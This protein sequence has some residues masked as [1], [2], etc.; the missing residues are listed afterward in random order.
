LFMKQNALTSAT[1]AAY[2]AVFQAQLFQLG[3]RSRLRYITLT[4]TSYESHTTV[5]YYDPF[6]Q[7]WSVADPTFG[8]LF[9]D[10]TTQTGQAVEE[11]QALVLANNFAGIHVTTVTT[12]S[13]SMLRNYY[14]DPLTLYTNVLPSDI[15]RI[16]SGLGSQPHSP[17]Q[18]LQE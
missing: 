18:F 7:K 10:P 14:L 6:V 15:T 16:S 8:F 13:D 17:F 2:S 4:G 9:F 11:V 12:Y 1:C 3:V 5:E